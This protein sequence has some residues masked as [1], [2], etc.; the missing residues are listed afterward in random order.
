MP[1]EQLLDNS[2][3]LKTLP[4]FLRQLGSAWFGAAIVVTA[5]LLGLYVV[6]LQQSI[7]P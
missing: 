1:A 5:T 2:S 4:P 7:I 3:S 6:Q